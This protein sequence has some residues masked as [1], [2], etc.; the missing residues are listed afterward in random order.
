MCSRCNEFIS[1][2]Y[3]FCPECG[4]S[5]KQKECKEPSNIWEYVSSL[6][7]QETYEKWRYAHSLLMKYQG[8]VNDI[9]CFDM[10]KNEVNRKFKN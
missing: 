9:E 6:D 4:S 10:I 8:D 1:N 3:K 7:T 5:L 2:G